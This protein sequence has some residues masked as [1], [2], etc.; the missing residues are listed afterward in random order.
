[1]RH[2]FGLLAA[3]AP[4]ALASTLIV[5]SV[6]MAQVTP[7]V[8]PDSLNAE[9]RQH[10]VEDGNLTQRFACGS[11]SEATGSRSTAVGVGA[12]ATGGQST[13]TG[14]TSSA[15]GSYSTATGYESGA[16]GT[17]STAAG[18][19]SRASGARST[20]LGV[21]SRA[22][23]DSSTATGFSSWATGE[24][25]TATG[26]LSEATGAYST[27][28]GYSASATGDFST[29]IGY[30]AQANGDGST[31]LGQGAIAEFAG[32]V[33]L[34]QGSETDRLNS[35]SI[36]RAGAERQLTN[37]AAG[38]AA[39]D[40]VNKSQLD[41]VSARTD[42]VAVNGSGP[43]P[44]AAGANAIALGSN[45]RATAGGAVAIGPNAV[46]SRPDQISLGSSASTYTMAGIASDASRAA[47]EG[48]LRLVTTDLAGNLGTS[49]LDIATL[50]GLDERTS[51]LEGRVGSLDAALDQGL[52]RA[53]AGI[54]AAMALGGTLLPPDSN[55]ALSFN[56]ATYRGEQGF[57]GAA[58]ARVTD[59]V[60]VSAGVAGSTVKGSTGG[61]AGVTFGW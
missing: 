41:A 10:L 27:S 36:G 42:Y 16:A 51:M 56:L 50:Q 11:G 2:N 14:A 28:M 49:T 6:A 3:A 43:L 19:L 55:F 5:P 45:A 9:C 23:D 1:M 61:R 48:A 18:Y 24:F 40:A 17:F 15:T 57:S 21:G 34:G 47:Q 60:W 46:A 8:G 12:T 20:A 4:L 32:S 13:A 58:V 35:V 37:L 38:T 54:A 30:D 53:D 52:R 44:V 26:S 31:A 33:A 7:D 29:V 39:T 59:T 22:I 25:S